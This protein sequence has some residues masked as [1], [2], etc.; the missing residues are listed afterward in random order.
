M[1]ARQREPGVVVVKRRRLP[2]GRRVTPCT[3]M[4]EVRGDVV[5]V[6]RPVEVRRMALVTVRIDQLIVAIRM[7]RLA[8]PCVWLSDGLLTAGPVPSCVDWVMVPEN[9]K[10]SADA[11]RPP[12]QTAKPAKS[13]K[14]SRLPALPAAE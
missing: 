5:R 1:C 9:V 13:Q 8:R 6:R 12:A 11:T 2:H 14:P 10:A 3:V 7:A 4:A